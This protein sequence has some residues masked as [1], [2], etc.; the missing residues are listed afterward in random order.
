MTISFKFKVISSLLSRNSWR[1]VMEAVN[2]AAV[3][4]DGL[5]IFYALI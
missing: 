3:G 4:N 1:Y 2:G 5:I